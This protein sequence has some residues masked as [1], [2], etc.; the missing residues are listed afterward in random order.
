[1]PGSN[2][3]VRYRARGALGGLQTVPRAELRAIHHCLSSIKDNPRIRQVTIYSD[4]K[5]AVDG[6]AKG[7]QYKS[8]T[9][10]GQRWSMVWDEYE[11]CIRHGISITVI[12]VKSHET[13]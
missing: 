12:K 9:K 6:I 10:L 13:D 4:C 3:E 7:S 8:K 11:A 2:K 5:M 1:M